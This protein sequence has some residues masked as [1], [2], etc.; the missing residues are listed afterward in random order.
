MNLHNACWDF[1]QYHPI[2]SL[3]AVG[4]KDEGITF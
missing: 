1:T 4:H 2:R 3:G